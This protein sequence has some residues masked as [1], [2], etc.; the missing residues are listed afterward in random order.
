MTSCWVTSLS[1]FEPMALHC[2]GSPSRPSAREE[3]QPQHS[4]GT[5]KPGMGLEMRDSRVSQEG[6]FPVNSKM[7]GSRWKRIITSFLSHSHSRAELVW[8]F[9]PS[10]APQ[11]PAQATA[12]FQHTQHWEPAVIQKQ[13]KLQTGRRDAQ[14]LCWYP[15]PLEK[16]LWY[17]WRCQGSWP[18]HQWSRVTHTPGTLVLR[19]TDKKCT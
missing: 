19:L 12:S 1:Y 5:S 15:L 16:E 2:M 18:R 4:R 3:C 7:D 11:C 9:P 10:A 17:S 14:Q 6:C 13:E 8:T